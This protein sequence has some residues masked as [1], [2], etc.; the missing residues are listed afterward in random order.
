MIDIDDGDYVACIC[1]GH[2]EIT[3]M[4]LLLGDDSLCFKREKLLDG[5]VLSTRYYRDS[6]L[7]CNRYLTMDYEGGRVVVLVI[8]DRK[9]VKYSIKNPYS[10]KVRFITY[11]IT[12][13]EVEM[14]MIHSLGYYE[15]YKKQKTKL[16]PSTYLSNKIKT[17]TATIK[18][19]EFIQD[20]WLKHDLASAIKTHKQKAQKLGKDEIFL[21]DLL[22]QKR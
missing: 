5:E 16:K 11:A 18:S 7:F 1:E 13:P 21:A 20:F 10:E 14:L 6:N 17:K 22:A 15:D 8:Q 9:G 4:N 2:S 12:S 19:K 3:I